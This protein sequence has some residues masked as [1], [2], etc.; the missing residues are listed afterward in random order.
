LDKAHQVLG[1]S[2]GNTPTLTI[3]LGTKVE[4]NDWTIENWS[5][6]LKKLSPNLKGWKLLV[7]GAADEAVKGD[8]CLEAW[9]KNGL[10]L[11]GQTPPRVSAAVLKKADIFIG[12]DSG[13]LDLAACVGTPC[14]G[15][16][17]ARNLPGRW[18]PKG[19]QHKIL[20]HK[21]D[22]AGCR[23]EV[24]IQQKK[25][26]ILSITVEE[27]YQ[28]VMELSDIQGQINLNSKSELS[29]AIPDKKLSNYENS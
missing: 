7:I 25:N 6:L 2:S 14:V 18:F 24:C 29:Q 27:V 8:H 23:L 5:A 9:G 11:C 3:S 19:N 4:A 16:F 26:C 20:Y 15:I 13:P 12:H 21:T 1:N 10:N 17:S 28:T 22:C